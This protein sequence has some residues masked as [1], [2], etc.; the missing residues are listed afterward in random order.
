MQ[1]R[2]ALV[3]SIVRVRDDQNIRLKALG[4]GPS[5]EQQRQN[6]DLRERYSQVFQDL[7]LSIPNPG[8]TETPDQYR[9]ELLSRLQSFSPTFR[10][11]DLRRLDASGG[12][13]YGIQQA[14]VQD[15]QNVATD[16]TQG[17]FRRPGALREIRRT[18]QTGQV[19]SVS[20]AGDPRAWM[21]AFVSPV[22]TMVEAFN[23][24]RR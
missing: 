6:N 12:L 8:A 11:S 24:R 13:A 14:I 1:S 20:F 23:Y 21:S 7:E 5:L 15:A 4:S 2:A 9:V 19:T 16:K 3:E 22:V 18:D 10:D 17:S